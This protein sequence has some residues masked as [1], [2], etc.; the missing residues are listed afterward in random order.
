M[1]FS[2]SLLSD[3]VYLASESRMNTW[4]HSVHS[5]SAASSLCSF[6]E[7]IWNT[8]LSSVA[9]SAISERAAIALETTM[10]LESDSRS[11]SSSRKPWWFMQR[12]FTHGHGVRVQGVRA[13]PG[14][15]GVVCGSLTLGPSFSSQDKNN[16]TTHSDR[17]VSSNI[18]KQQAFSKI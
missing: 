16:G 14:E 15:D 1:M 12:W 13:E 3:G 18:L 7:L 4:P 5:L 11:L 8:S 2:A 17:T 10:G 9:L 6:A